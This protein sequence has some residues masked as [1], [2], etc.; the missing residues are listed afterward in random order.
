IASVDAALGDPKALSLFF[1]IPGLGRTNAIEKY[2]ASKSLVTWSADVV[3]D[4]WKR[5]SAREIVRR[6][7]R[8]LDEKG[9]GILLLHD[10]HQTT[11]SALP[12]LLKELK[13]RG[14]SVVQVVA[15]SE[16]PATVPE[17]PVSA[18]NNKGS[19]QRAENAAQDTP[20]S[21]ASP[22]RTKKATNGK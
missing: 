6:T 14:Y 2:L 8:R 17:L 12:I 11:A 5:I 22:H 7:M 21:T 3:G 13:D 19:P 4:D 20:G 18:D 16:R 9:G 10:I 1:R 15:D